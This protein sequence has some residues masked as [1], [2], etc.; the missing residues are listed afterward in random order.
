[1][2]YPAIADPFLLLSVSLRYFSSTFIKNGVAFTINALDVEFVGFWNMAAL[3]LL[4]QHFSTWLDNLELAT[5][6]SFFQS[7][8]SPFSLHIV[9]I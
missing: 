2:F 3:L 8:S 5:N 4:R 6:T 7:Q 9:S 1:M